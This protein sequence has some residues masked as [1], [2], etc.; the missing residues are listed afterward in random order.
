MEVCMRIPI[1]VAAI[2]VAPLLSVLAFAE[3]RPTDEERGEELY[4]RHCIQCHG[5]TSAGDGPA[6][7]TLIV[8]VPDLSKSLLEKTSDDTIKM[9]LNGK[10]TMPSFQLS[11]DKHDAR[12]VLKHM[13]RIT[14]PTPPEAPSEETADVNADSN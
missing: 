9:V 4:N 5:P 7:S 8:P 11:F 2:V 13:E 6:T 12:R 1:L 14:H 10:G 3:P